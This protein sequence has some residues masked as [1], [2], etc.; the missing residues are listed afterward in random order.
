M[1]TRHPDTLDPRLIDLLDELI[2]APIKR[3]GLKHMLSKGRRAARRLGLPCNPIGAGT[4]KL[5]LAGTYRPVGKTCPSSCPLLD[6]GCYAQQGQVAMQQRRASEELLASLVSAAIVMVCAARYR[7]IARLHVS[8]DFYT[9]TGQLDLA[10]L[11]GLINLGT[12]LRSQLGSSAP[13][14]YTYTHGEDM[15]VWMWLLRK[16]G[17]LVRQS[18]MPGHGGCVVEP[19]ESVPALK[20]AHPQLTFARCR[21]QLDD[22]TQCRDCKLCW[23]REDLTIVFAPHGSQKR[24]VI[25]YSRRA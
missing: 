14:A 12:R 10:Y 13:L 8:G 24:K 16:A 21:A 20:A 1:S 5:G 11:C 6:R 2:D 15:G 9:P 23:E 3:G 22:I 25:P 4:S 18:G 7:Q 19:F 17:V